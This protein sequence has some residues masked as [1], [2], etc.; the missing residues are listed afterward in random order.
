MQRDFGNVYQRN[1]TSC[2][3]IPELIFKDY[4]CLRQMTPASHEYASRRP[5]EIY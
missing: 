2:N 4:M 5:T 3:T 1:Q